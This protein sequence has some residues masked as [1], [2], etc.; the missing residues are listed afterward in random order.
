MKYKLRGHYKSTLIDTIL[1]N[2]GITDIEEFKCPTGKIKT[3]LT[4]IINIDA[5][6]DLIVNNLDKK[7]II[8]VDSDVDGFSS[9]SLIYQFLKEVK[10]DIDI[11]YF[12]HETKQHG[13]TSSFINFVQF[14]EVDII[15]VPDAGSNDVEEIKFLESLG[16]KVIILDHHEVEKKNDV[17]IVINNQICE[18]TNNNF[19]GVGMTYLFAKAMNEKMG[20][21]IDLTKYEDLLLIGSVGDGASIIEEELRYYCER[22]RKNIKNTLIKTFYKK[23][24]IDL[25]TYTNLSFSGII[26]AINAIVRAG[27]LKEKKLLF[28]ALNDIEADY[29]EKVEKRKLNKVTRKYN[30]V[31]F[32]YNLYELAIEA[33]ENAKERQDK[34]IKQKIKEML[35]QYNNEA[36]GVFRLKEDDEIKS[37]A[38]VLA[39]KIAGVIKVP[40]IVVWKDNNGNYI[41]S[42]R[43][44]IKVIADFKE[45]CLQTKLFE[46]AQGHANAFGVI[47]KE[48][49][50]SKIKDLAA[51]VEKEDFC[52]EVDVVY[53][54]EIKKQHF[55]IINDC[56]ELWCNGC[57][58]PLV[59]IKNLK[60]KKSNISIKGSVLKIFDKG[61]SYIKF[62][63][64]ENE[65][66]EI[67]SK[68]FG[69]YI[70]FSIIGRYSL[71]E[72]NGN[73]YPQI[74]IEDYEFE[75]K[76]SYSLKG[77]FG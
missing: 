76:N 6:I 31:T 68:G 8:C 28:K 73:R 16:K 77:F 43:G 19:T 24:E 60:V 42:G 11:D 75:I 13:L 58:E 62:K 67:V 51:N 30:Q 27:T 29:T 39:N 40:T 48:D 15:I 57:E 71:N 47:F 55:Y 9:A 7:F 53:N 32:T 33:C 3:D 4:K 37:I 44:N 25:I 35:P 23:K 5:G 69:D 14:K 56:K 54:A 38:G 50:F 63:S 70:E 64:N 46:L 22:A 45:W 10:E 61:I 18:H 74:I 21:G 72:Y 2:R 52:Y 34:I 59:A 1:N 20:Y 65:Y 12:I 41:G 26:P 49:N 66:N 17:G 36:I